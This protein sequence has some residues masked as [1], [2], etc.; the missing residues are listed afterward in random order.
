[1]SQNARTA[2][3][4]E[5]DAGSYHRISGPQ[6]SWGMRV[7]DRVR[8]R[9]DELVVDA[10]CGSGRLTAELLRRLPRGRVVAVDQSANMLAEARVHLEPEFGSRVHFIRADLAALEL[11]EPADGVF[12]TATFHW[13]LNHERLFASLFGVLRP[14]GWLVAQCGGAGNLDRLHAR[15]E[16]LMHQEP[17]AAAFRDWRDPW[18]FAGPADT[19]QRLQAAGFVDIGTSLEPAPIR[20]ETADEYRQF[21][22]TVVLRHHLARLGAEARQVFL[23]RLTVKAGGDRPP[24][25]LDYV[26]LN[27]RAQRPG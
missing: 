9:G 13:V 16:E 23:D 11:D 7:L 22:E 3:D 12:S 14:G 10:G 27:L 24:Y 2:T 19:E 4:R 20:F 15:A 25:L 5:W 8:L 18:L 26:R 17:F 21:L 1:M 6:F